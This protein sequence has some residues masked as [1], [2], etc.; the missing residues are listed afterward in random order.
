MKLSDFSTRIL[1][2]WDE[3]NVHQQSNKSK[4]TS[5]HT[6]GLIRFF[7]SKPHFWDE[8]NLNGL[9]RFFHS[10]NQK[11]NLPRIANL[12]RAPKMS[13]L[14]QYKDLI[15]F[16]VTHIKFDLH[17]DDFSG[18]SLRHAIKTNWPKQALSQLLLFFMVL[19][20]VNTEERKFIV[21]PT[22]KKKKTSLDSIKCLAA[23]T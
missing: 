21:D 22:S 5:W 19:N 1:H 14:W 20:C 3:S 16:D 15:Y 7:H 6:Y 12:G 18:K 10:M 13:C 2:F 8:S 9:N 23:L 17:L 4:F 11:K